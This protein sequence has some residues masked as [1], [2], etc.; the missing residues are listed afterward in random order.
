MEKYKVHETKDTSYDYEVKRKPENNNTLGVI[1]LVTGILAIILYFC[2]IGLDFLLGII[3]LITGI[4]GHKEGQD[5]ALAGMILGIV[6]LSLY[7]MLFLGIFA[8]TGIST[9]FALF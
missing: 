3:A 8:L 1:S 6:V 2:C 7:L 9:I 5:Y 4:I